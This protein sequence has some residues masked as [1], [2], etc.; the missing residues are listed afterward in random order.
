M[1]KPDRIHSNPLTAIQ[2]SGKNTIAS[3]FKSRAVWAARMPR[4]IDR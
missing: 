2:C 1:Y 4:R 3:G